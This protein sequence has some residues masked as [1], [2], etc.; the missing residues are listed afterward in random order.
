M[1]QKSI[2]RNLEKNLRKENTALLT[3]MHLNFGKINYTGLLFCQT[4]NSIYFTL[5]S[6]PEIDKFTV[7]IQSPE[8]HNVLQT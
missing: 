4:R 5:V 3:S 7:K 2:T 1:N 6:L 8:V